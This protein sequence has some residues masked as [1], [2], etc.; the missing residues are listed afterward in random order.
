[1]TSPVIL[2]GVNA[3]GFHLFDTA[4][5]T[6]GVGWNDDA[7]VTVALPEDDVRSLTGLESEPTPLAR[8]AV[9][10]IRA[11]LAGDAVDLGAIP[12]ALDH[13]PSF[14]REVYAVTRTI[15]RGRTLTYGQV[16]ALIGR[17]KAAQAVGRALGRNPVPI[18][19]PC[20]RILGA[21]TEVGGFSAPGGAATKAKILAAEGVA[22]FEEPTLF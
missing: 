16:A 19:V 21:G 8:T 12:V 22:G 4:F 18:V 14:D 13:L 7:I 6:C 9:D 3:T 1:M 15:P 11:L 2:G 20:H 17:P 10:G 5:G